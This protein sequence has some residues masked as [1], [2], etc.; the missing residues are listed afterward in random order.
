MKLF[1]LNLI[2]YFLF[3]LLFS[4]MLVSSEKISQTQQR[5]KETK[6]IIKQKRKEKQIYIDKQKNV[7]EDLRKIEQELKKIN[8]EKKDIEKKAYQTRLTISA[9]ENNLRIL[10]SDMDFYTRILN[11]SVRNYIEK[12]YILSNFLEN[13]FEKRLKKDIFKEFSR[14]IIRT[15]ETLNYT[16]EL[17]KEYEKEKM[18]LSNLNNQL[19]QKKQQQVSLYRKKA[20]LLD[21]L[22]LKQKK[23]DEEIAELNRT[24]KEL[25]VLLKRLY[26]EE[27]ERQARLQKEREKD[28]KLKEKKVVKIERKFIKPIEGA[29]ISKFGKTL[30]EGRCVV[31]NG[32]VIQGMSNSDV[33]CVEDGKVLFISNNFRSYGKIIIIEHRDNIHTIYA[34]LGEILVVEGS[35]V[36]KS[37]T[38]AKTD[39]SGR[40]YFEVRKDLVAVDP[41]LYFE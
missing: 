37:T 25:E 31:K 32:V 17:K 16:E 8:L 38:I 30:E 20:E 22:K 15:R 9:L 13:N 12:H 2:R 39:N 1:N 11:I 28:I 21:E 18:K 4:Y 6:D 14:Q 40:I 29:I 35:W 33:V 7:Q 5:L 34:N 24:Q 10:S 3:L 41:E 36:R 19:E 27:R 23:I 26:R